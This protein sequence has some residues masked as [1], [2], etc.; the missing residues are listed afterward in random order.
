[1]FDA[2]FL[3]ELQFRCKLSKIFSDSVSIDLFAGTWVV[4]T[5]SES[6]QVCE[7]YLQMA[8]VGLEPTSGLREPGG[9]VAGVDRLPEEMS[10]MRIRDD[11]V[12]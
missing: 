11:K 7:I 9:H 5:S 10:D 8:S 12:C 4:W 6:K 3:F 1:M 2:T